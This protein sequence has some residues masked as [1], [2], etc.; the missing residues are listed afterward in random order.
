MTYQERET[1]LV[2]ALT[3]LF[4]R[5]AQEYDDWADV[6][7]GDGDDGAEVRAVWKFEELA[8]AKFRA[9]ATGMAENLLAQLDEV[10]DETIEEVS[11]WKCAVGVSY[12]EYAE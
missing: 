7:I 10:V 1:A 12:R 5:A 9:I 4:V 3:Q 2:A 11:P 8:E 6:G